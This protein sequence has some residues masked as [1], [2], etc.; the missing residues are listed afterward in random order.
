[1]VPA[2]IL[3]VGFGALTFGFM[4]PTM[5]R[6]LIGLIAVIF[7]LNYW[8]SGRSAAEARGRSRIKGSFWS[9]VSGFT[10]FLT[11]AGGPPINVYL[12]PQRMDMT[13]FVGTKLVLFIIVNYV[14]LVAYAWLG[15][16]HAGNL[17]TSLV[18]IPLAPVG[19]GLGLWLH[20]RINN[21]LFYRICYVILFLVGVRLLYGGVSDLL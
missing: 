3:G 13:L 7:T 19:V 21:E 4:S 12:L 18:L 1:M 17:A 2:A 16:L 9:A 14:K 6:I 10:S 11:H 15:Q 5:I 8:L 20:R